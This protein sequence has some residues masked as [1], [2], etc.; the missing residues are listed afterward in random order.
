V[1]DP[2]GVGPEHEIAGRVLVDLL[3][4]HRVAQDVLDVLRFDTVAKC[5]AST[6]TTTVVLRNCAHVSRP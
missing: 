4:H 5:R 3:H 1:G 2:G 6:S